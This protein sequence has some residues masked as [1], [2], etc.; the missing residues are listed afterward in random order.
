MFGDPRDDDCV[1]EV[2]SISGGRLAGEGES[3]YGIIDHPIGGP[4][5]L[6]RRAAAVAPGQRAV[7]VASGGEDDF[8]PKDVQWPRI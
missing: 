1:E 4:T 7:G 2:L 8:A 6:T 5:N 3:W